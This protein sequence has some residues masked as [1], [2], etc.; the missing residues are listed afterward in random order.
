MIRAEGVLN[1]SVTDTSLEKINDARL[2]QSVFGRIFGFGTLDILTAAEEVGGKH[3]RLPDDRRPGG[4]QEGD[5]RSEDDAREPGPR[6]P[7][8]SA[9]RSTDGA[10]GPMPPRAGSDR[11]AVRRCARRGAS[12]TAPAAHA[13]AA[14]PSPPPR[15]PPMTWAPRSAARRPARQGAHHAGG[16]RGQ[17]ARAAGAHVVPD[18]TLADLR[19]GAYGAELDRRIAGATDIIRAPRG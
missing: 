11:V 2:D 15:V 14:G 10:R 12:R 8:F 18:A 19:D 9:R 5:V 16:V 6:P 13:G 4:L 3:L 7:R 17:E 1:K